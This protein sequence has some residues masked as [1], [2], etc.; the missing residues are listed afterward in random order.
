MKVRFFPRARKNDKRGN[1]YRSE[2][3]LMVRE[4]SVARKTL[5]QCFIG[6]G[7]YVPVKHWGLSKGQRRE[8]YDRV[9]PVCPDAKTVNPILDKISDTAYRLIEEALLY[10]LDPVAYVRD[11]IRTAN[12][13]PRVGIIDTVDP[14]TKDLL[15][16][17]RL[18]YQF[19]QFTEHQKEQGLQRSAT[20][21]SYATTFANLRK[22]IESEGQ[23]ELFISHIT[24]DWR[25]RFVKFLTERV[26]LR[27]STVS[28]T[29]ANVR[30]VLHWT[31]ERGVEHAERAAKRL[32][33]KGMTKETWAVVLGR[34]EIEKL[35]SLKF[36]S[37]TQQH[38]ETA[39]DGFLFSI[40]TGLRVSDLS[41]LQPMHESE[42]W[43]T[44]SA[45]KVRKKFRIPLSECA[46]AIWNRYDGP[47]P[48][49]CPQKFN[50]RIK[51]LCEM[52]DLDKVMKEKEIHRGVDVVRE[53]VRFSDVVSIHTARRTFVTLSL[54]AGVEERTVMMTTG[55]TK[56]EQ[57][58][59]YDR[60]EG[61]VLKRKELREWWRSRGSLIWND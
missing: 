33:L 45:V 59:I 60:Y 44:K 37:A 55:H 8:V 50:K 19:Q 14:A 21:Q 3:V 10:E 34:P 5:K 29:L 23:K 57:L 17:D 41:G 56:H 46:R 32:H 31:S 43:I 30:A 28:K 9:D 25:D 20:A 13:L 42:G 48:V 61:E 49:G 27:N 18:L 11:N 54:N 40:Y 1:P 47:V 51:K 12:V 36:D 39:R 35:E 58:N 52:I 24:T 7:L 15:R 2:I 22:M 53:T 26:G 16:N 38:L 4:G 6:T